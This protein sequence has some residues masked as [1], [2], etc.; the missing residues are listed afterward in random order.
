[1]AARIASKSRS[2]IATPDLML[3]G[4]LATTLL[5]HHPHPHPLLRLHRHY[6]RPHH[7]LQRPCPTFPCWCGDS[8]LEQTQR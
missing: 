5:C 4:V 3:G 1:M 7:L 6:C 2:K 8:H